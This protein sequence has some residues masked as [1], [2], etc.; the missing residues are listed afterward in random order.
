MSKGENKRKSVCGDLQAYMLFVQILDTISA[1]QPLVLAFTA[2]SP[3]PRP[4]ARVVPVM[5][6]SELSND[7]VVGCLYVGF[8]SLPTR[9]SFASSPVLWL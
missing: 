8:T 4:P 1:S 7:A 2:P 9:D 3:G 5:S 6:P